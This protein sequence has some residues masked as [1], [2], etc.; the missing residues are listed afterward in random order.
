MRWRAIY[1]LSTIILVMAAC[2]AVEEPVHT[3]TVVFNPDS[4]DAENTCL[5]SYD[6]H[7]NMV[8]IEVGDGPVVGIDAVVLTHTCDNSRYSGVKIDHYSKLPDVVVGAPLGEP[9]ASP[10]ECVGNFLTMES[11]D[12]IMLMLGDIVHPGDLLEVVVVD[13]ATCEAS[14]VATNHL[15][16]SIATGAGLDSALLIGEGTTA[17]VAPD[18]WEAI[19]P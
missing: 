10:S 3:D 7:W 5:D 8:L 19:L 15:K 11:G 2:S 9:D 13:P 18:E 1:T 4:V 6:P 12:F 14:T 17:T 16:L